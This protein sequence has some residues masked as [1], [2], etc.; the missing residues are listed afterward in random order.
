M[1]VLQKKRTGSQ[2]IDGTVEKPL[3]LFLVEVHRDDVRQTGIAHHFRQQLRHDAP[4]LPHL[5]LF[6]V[7]QVGNYGNDRLGRRRFASVRHDQQLHDV[8]VDV[9]EADTKTCWFEAEADET[10]N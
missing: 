5:A 2:V 7:R 9:S 1:D 8:V 6:T 3:R 10:I 4:P